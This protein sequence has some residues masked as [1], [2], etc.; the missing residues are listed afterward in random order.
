MTNPIFKSRR[1]HRKIGLD[2]TYDHSKVKC[3]Q[4]TNA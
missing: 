2:T 4:L 1:L 3:N